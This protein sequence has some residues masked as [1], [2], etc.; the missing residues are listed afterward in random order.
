MMTKSATVLMTI[1]KKKNDA[2]SYTA[3][4]AEEIYG[5]A[6]SLGY[7]VVVLRGNDTTYD[8]VTNAIETYKPRVFIHTGHGC[9]S[10][11]NGNN[12]CIV[13]RKYS[14]GELMKMDSA[15]LDKMFNPVKLGNSCGKD[16]CSLQGDI[17]M[18]LCFNSTNINL[19][20]NSIVIANACHSSSILGR[21]A[22]AYG[23][24]S[25]VGYSDLLLFPTDTMKS[26]NIFKEI[27]VELA[28]SILMGQ[29]VGEANNIARSMEDAYIRVYKGYK[30]VALPMIWNT[31][32]REVLGNREATIY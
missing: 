12:D 22:I 24:Q 29:S 17:C 15:K 1:P 19:L 7:N 31:M 28:R 4:W 20:K 9:G 11:L 16:T 10:A 18:P 2:T 6:K 5:I 8:K 14:I 30:W 25:Y 21:C 32:H 26:E 3:S 23:V 27:H 13:T